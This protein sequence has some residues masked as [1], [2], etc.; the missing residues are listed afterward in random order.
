MSDF[1]SL[2]TYL[3]NDSTILKKSIFS[4]L[5]IAMDDIVFFKHDSSQ[6]LRFNEFI[7]L[8]K[9]A[10]QTALSE[11]CSSQAGSMYFFF[12]SETAF[13]KNSWNLYKKK[14]DDSG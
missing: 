1:C 9:T 4:L 2:E 8:Y 3:R 12:F 14:K 13:L 6:K 10:K 5:W 11:N 7:K